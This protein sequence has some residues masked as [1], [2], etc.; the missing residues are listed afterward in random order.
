LNM[1]D[2]PRWVAGITEAKADAQEL[3]KNKEFKK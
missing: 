1:Q 3:L 2:D